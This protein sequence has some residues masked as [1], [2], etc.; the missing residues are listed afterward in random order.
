MKNLPIGIQ[1]FR[2]I[3]EGGYVYADKTGYIAD[4]AR[5]GKYFFLS[6]PRRFGKSLFIDTVKQAFSGEGDLFSGLA[7]AGT[8][9]DFTPRPV[10]RL[11]LSSIALAD[12]DELR[13]GLM[14]LLRDTAESFQVEVEGATPAEYFRRLIHTLH[15]TSGHRVVVLID[16]YDKPIIDHMDD[17][18]LAES[19]RKELRYFYGVLKAMDAHLRFVLLTGVAKFTR[20]SVFS[21][22]NN[23]IDISMNPAFANI[24]G[25]TEQE[26]DA[27][28]PEHLA[29]YAQARRDLGIDDESLPAIRDQVF[30]WY[31]GYSWDGVT[32][33]F[34]PFSL[35]SFFLKREFYPFWFT[36]GIPQFLVHHVRD[37]PGAYA[38]LEGAQITE[39]TLD[40]YDIERAPLESLLFQTGFLTVRSAN[41]R[42]APVVYTIGFP[43]L[44]V[45]QSFSGWFLDT[46]SGDLAGMEQTQRR[47][48]AQAFNDGR[49]EDL[50]DCLTGLF[51]AIPYNL[52]MKAE[53][54]YHAVFLSVVRVLGLRVTGEAA[55]AG[56]EADATITTSTGFA[57]VIEMK[58]V[59]AGDDA[60]REHR[61][62]Q[63]AAAA[64]R[65]IAARGYADQFRGTACRLHH[66]GVAVADRGQV[67]V[68]WTVAENR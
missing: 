10:I 21:Q 60:D 59:P 54:F 9:F 6:R 8:D 26:F 49:P 45:S 31:D 53:A 25:F 14:G 1:T 23:L 38:A 67:H 3:I 68:D 33:V 47:R 66:V 13:S 28:F 2:T 30:T 39:V 36:S 7:L 40:S 37:N 61:L 35:L 11:D 4:L 19:N 63:A 18:A 57:Y 65:Q 46:L 34:N 64:L 12:S 27:L 29:A 16:E 43:N 22:L 41:R 44:E 32:R 51:A 5:Q 15:Q 50:E 58:Y 42:E 20:T 48:L 62:E 52:H 55:V 24:C 56:G 17:R